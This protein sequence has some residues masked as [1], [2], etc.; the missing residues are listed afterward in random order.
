MRDF[1]KSDE[2]RGDSRYIFKFAFSNLYHNKYIL[3]LWFFRLMIS[4]NGI[5][6]YWSNDRQ[7]VGLKN[8]SRYF[9]IRVY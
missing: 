9:S 2:N 4:Y 3:K 8:L 6:E 7:P 1:C 5:L